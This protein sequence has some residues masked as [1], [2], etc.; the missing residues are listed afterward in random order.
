M[1]RGFAQRALVLD[2]VFFLLDHHGHRLFPHGIIG[3]LIDDHKHPG[4]ARFH[5]GPAAVAFFRIH[6]DEILAGAVFVT[7][8]CQH[9]LAV[10]F[11]PLAAS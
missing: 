8:V 9:G 6:G 10:P 2:F 7:V 4:R 11:T 1:A 3:V 5:A